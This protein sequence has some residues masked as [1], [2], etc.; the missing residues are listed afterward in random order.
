VDL[1]TDLLNTYYYDIH[2]HLTRSRTGHVV[3]QFGVRGRVGNPWIVQCYGNR[4]VRNVYRHGAF[5]R[6]GA[7]NQ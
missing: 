7:G 2:T 5:H 6:V 1:L 3:M 4:Q